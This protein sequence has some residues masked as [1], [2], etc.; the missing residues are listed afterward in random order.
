M[1]GDRRGERQAKLRRRLE[2]LS[3]D[4][5]LVTHSPNIRYLTGF[6]GSA[7]LLL[8]TQQR[9]ALITDFRYAEQAPGETRGAADVLVEQRN[10]WDRLRAT[11]SSGPRI[12][13][14]FERDHL[15]VR[16]AERLS[17]VAGA[18]PVPVSDLVE[19]L[20]CVKDPGEVAAIA[21]AAEL[22][23]AALAELLPT[24]KVGA[25]ERDIAARLEAGLRRRGSEWHPFRTIVAS[26][27]RSALPHAQASERAVARGEWLLLDFG[28]ELD[29]YCADLTRTLVLG[30]AAD[31][32][33][34]EVYEVVRAAQRKA[35]TELRPGMSGREGD[36][37]ARD[38]ISA[39]G[40]G[41]AF[42]HSLG[43]GLGLEVHEAPR[44]A[45]TAQ[46]ALPA[47]A[48]VTVEP[49]IYLEGWGGVRLEDDVH[50]TPDGPR[51]LTDGRTELLE[52]H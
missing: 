43:H 23:Q 12:R 44:L 11:L 7:G 10:L 25:T 51:C 8:L 35:L 42:G 37:L 9:S 22:A 48:V 21:G 20:R 27:P 50:L 34:R 39:A 40:F 45:L 15:T 38:L 26:G 16:D 14:G 29:G 30:A 4:A 46:E 17:G 18:E 41:D 52:I 5:L 13:F 33:Q 36:A 2:E 28:A 6:T 1:A 19:A 32:R 31:G 24:L 49:G 47:G 3:L